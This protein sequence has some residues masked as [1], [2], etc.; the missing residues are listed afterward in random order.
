MRNFTLLLLLHLF[1]VSLS[2]KNTL[3]TEVTT[4]SELR[5][6]LS[7][8]IPPLHYH[9]IFLTSELTLN[10]PIRLTSHTELYGEPGGKAS[11]QFQHLDSESGLILH[12]VS[13]VSVRDVRVAYDNENIW[14]N[15]SAVLSVQDSYNVFLE[16]LVIEGG[17]QISGGSLIDLSWSNISNHKG[18]QNGTCV[19]V[20]G[21]GVSKSL[22]SCNLTIHD[23]LIHDCRYDGVSIYDS[24]AQGILLGAQSGAPS[25][26][27]NGGCTV[28][29]V[30]RNNNVQGVDEMGIRVATDV[31][32]ST[33]LN[34]V[35]YNRVSDW[36][37]GSRAN[38][39]D[40]ADSGCLYVYGH[41]YSPGNVFEANFCNSTS[42]KTWGQN[43]AYLDD[44][45][46]GNTFKGNFFVGAINGEAVKLNGGQFNTIDSNVVYRGSALGSANCR[47][48]RPP[49]NYIYTCENNN[50]G[51]RWMKIL[52]SNGYREP[53]W[54]LT[55]P[56]F[57]GWCTNTT[58]GP[59]NVPCAPQGAPEGYEC[60]ALSRGN[61]AGNFATISA[62]RNTTF[63]VITSPGFPFQNWS[64]ACPDY[65]VTGSYN[66][67]DLASQ[68]AYES[69]DVFVNAAGGDLTLR[70]DSQIFIDMPSFMKVNF[71]SIGVGG[72]G[73]RGRAIGEALPTAER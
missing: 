9:R 47:G 17:V 35:S 42:N 65:V 70:S 44:S 23:N 48:L 53:P 57:N 2:S 49:L 27:T 56:F 5:A 25:N 52:E 60:A 71:L 37:Q 14:Y 64:S 55:F 39:G 68:F 45:A 22:T 38:G 13:D 73:G 36:G 3:D 28:G 20:P 4:E 11:L 33:V 26:T 15:R 61:S 66:E 32:C 62:V 50:T 19:Y 46:S 40:G 41:W 54:S 63:D 67:I 16:G 10:S 29:V 58:A 8:Q 59:D 24:S 6:A 72:G 31:P 12:S 18:S 43:G 7:M 1:P 69:D 51:A 21:C 34:N 30:V